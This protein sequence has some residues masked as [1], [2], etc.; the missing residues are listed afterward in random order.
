MAD[1]SLETDSDRIAQEQ[2][3]KAHAD[4]KHRRQAGQDGRGGKP[5]DSKDEPSRPA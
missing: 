5:D 2:G 1:K 4:E 3:S